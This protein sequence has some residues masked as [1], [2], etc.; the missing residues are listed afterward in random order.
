MGDS[1]AP[2]GCITAVSQAGV[3]WAGE[4]QVRIWGSSEVYS[5]GDKPDCG[6]T[7]WQ[8]KRAEVRVGQPEERWPPALGCLRSHLQKEGR[9]ALSLLSPTPAPAGSG[10]LS[11]LAALGTAVPRGSCPPHLCL[12]L[13]QHSPQFL[14]PLP[15]PP[16]HTRPV[17]SPHFSYDSP[18]LAL[19][20]GKSA[21]AHGS[22]PTPEVFRTRSNHM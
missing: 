3:Q 21:Q 19:P 15:G 1:V 5:L 14:L 7:M 13:S 2:L 9:P 16:C 12:L 20:S 22:A 17:G 11:P 18:V 4:L 8:G 6:V 10:C